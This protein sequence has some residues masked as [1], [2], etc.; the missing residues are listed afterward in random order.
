[1][2]PKLA[3]PENFD[4]A[5]KGQ[6]DKLLWCQAGRCT[7]EYWKRCMSLTNLGAGAQPPAG[8]LGGDLNSQLTSPLVRQFDAKQSHTK[9]FG[10]EE[11]SA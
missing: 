5:G 6:R 9:T 11:H 1:M 10:G 3:V 4:C 8:L 2:S 7:G